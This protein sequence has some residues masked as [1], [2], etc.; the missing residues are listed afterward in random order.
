MVC[1]GLHW[2]EAY[3]DWVP[4]RGWETGWG[5]SVWLLLASVLCGFIEI[6]QRFH[7]STYRMLDS[8]GGRN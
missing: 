6:S 5:S 3:A 4:L 7:V 1:D 2:A 8:K